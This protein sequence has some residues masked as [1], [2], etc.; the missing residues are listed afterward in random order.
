MAQLKSDSKV[1]GKQIATVQDM[2]NAAGD[3]VVGFDRPAFHGKIADNTI[4]WMYDR[5]ERDLAINPILDSNEGWDPVMN[6]YRIPKPGIYRIMA[7][8]NTYNLRD[9]TRFQLGVRFVDLNNQH[10]PHPNNHKYSN[11]AINGQIVTDTEIRGWAPNKIDFQFKFL[12]NQSEDLYDRVQ[13]VI[14]PQPGYYGLNGSTSVTTGIGG[15]T[16]V[17]FSTVSIYYVGPIK[18]GLY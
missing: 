16:P 3:A 4:W 9:N 18:E 13:F 8:I 1:G 6:C 12:P 5:S 7:N 2:Q 10:N 11:I 14:T 15:P 17:R